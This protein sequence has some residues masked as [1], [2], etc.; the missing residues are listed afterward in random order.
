MTQTNFRRWRDAMG[1]TQ[2]EAAQKLGL[3]ERQIRHFDHGVHSGTGNPSSPD[4]ATRVLMRLLIEKK[5]PNPW[6]K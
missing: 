6:P 4:Y 2:D 3:A 5:T 1:L